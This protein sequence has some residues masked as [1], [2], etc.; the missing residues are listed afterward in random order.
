MNILYNKN[1]FFFWI[2]IKK[3]LLYKF[4]IYLIND[5]NIKIKMILSKIKIKVNYI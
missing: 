5:N 1:K 3:L 4:F 2:F